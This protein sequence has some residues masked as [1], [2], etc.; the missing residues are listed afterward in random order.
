[1][2]SE[3][4]RTESKVMPCLKYKEML[5]KHLIEQELTCLGER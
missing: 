4:E 5:V 1:M 3:S 2:V